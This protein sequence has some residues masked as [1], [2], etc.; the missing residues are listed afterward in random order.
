MSKGPCRFRFNKGFLSPSETDFIFFFSEPCEEAPALFC[1]QE[2][3][4][5]MMWLA[6]GMTKEPI[7]ER[8]VFLQSE[9]ILA[10]AETL[11]W[12]LLNLYFYIPKASKTTSP[13]L[14]VRILH[15]SRGCCWNFLRW[16]QIWGAEGPQ[17]LL[18]IWAFSAWTWPSFGH[19]SLQQWLECMGC[20]LV[21]MDSIWKDNIPI[22]LHLA[23]FITKT[24]AHFSYPGVLSRIFY[25]IVKWLDHSASILPA[26]LALLSG[27][28]R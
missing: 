9:K 14:S 13:F 27:C 8:M 26:C 18:N 6:R 12:M 1:F 25:I 23:F 10:G 3:C 5:W 24:E 11:L 17:Y 4:V 28:R 21:R 7:A 20:S 15:L 22:R 2:G 19:I 16:R